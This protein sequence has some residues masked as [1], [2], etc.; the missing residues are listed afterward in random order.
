[1]AKS[2]TQGEFHD[3]E[4]MASQERFFLPGRQNPLTFPG[5]SEAMQILVG[6]RDEAHRFAITYHR[7]LRGERSL[8]SVLDAITGLG[9]KRKKAL[10]KAF[11]S[12]DAIRQASVEQLTEL[13]QMNRVIAER[14]LVQ[15][16]ELSQNEEE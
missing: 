15:L 9:E 16:K 2:R 10:L 13:P 4:V 1:M 8:G 5:N 3:Q 12:V 6:I 14:V 7:K 11:G